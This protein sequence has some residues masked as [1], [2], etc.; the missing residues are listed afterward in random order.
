MSATLLYRIA[1]VLLI[2]FAAG[3]T[4]GFLKFKP[5]TA[6]GVAVRDAMDTVQFSVGSGKSTYGDFY[7]GFGLFCTVYLLFTSFLAW[8]LGGMAR[9]NPQSIA[10]LSW[11]FFALQLASI[12]L[13]WKYFFAPPIV[14]STLAAVCSGWASW[15]IS[16]A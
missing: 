9:T 6:E 4:V 10:T 12:A 5:P 3:H 8:H 16:R 11:V 2:L 14:F 1:A 13:A 7:R 15:L